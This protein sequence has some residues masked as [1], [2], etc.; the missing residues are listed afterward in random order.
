MLKHPLIQVILDYPN[1]RIMKHAKETYDWDN[2][3]LKEKNE[4][5]LNI[6]RYANDVEMVMNGDI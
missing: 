4:Q 2:L 6:L 1:K 3:T 5:S